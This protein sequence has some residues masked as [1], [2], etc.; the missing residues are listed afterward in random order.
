[1]LKKG[2]D[3]L[4]RNGSFSVTSQC[5]CRAVCFVFSVGVFFYFPI[6]NDWKKTPT[7]F[8]LCFWQNLMVIRRDIHAKSGL[9]I[10][11][12]GLEM[13]LPIGERWRDLRS[14]RQRFRAGAACHP[15][16]ESNSAPYK[17]RALDN[18]PGFLLAELPNPGNGLQTCWW[19]TRH[20]FS[21]IP[22]LDTRNSSMLFS[23]LPNSYL[24]QNED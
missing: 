1:M 16:A 21:S 19:D 24:L 8:R 5:H 13:S 20:S 6:K 11:M 15:P 14:S 7:F 17:M 22:T 23:V 2:W 12:S 9:Y 3:I 18:A 4:S 10:F